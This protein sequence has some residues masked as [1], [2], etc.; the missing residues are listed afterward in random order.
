MAY[1][2]YFSWIAFICGCSF[3][4]FSADFMLVMRSGN[5]ARLMTTVRRMMATPQLCAM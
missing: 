4:I 2:L 1:F 3:C 5:S